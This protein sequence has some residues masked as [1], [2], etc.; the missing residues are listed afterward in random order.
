MKLIFISA[1]KVKNQEILALEKD[2]LRRIRNA[3]V[4]EVPP[5]KQAKGEAAH[6]EAILQV[7]SR[8][9]RLI[10]LDEGGEQLNSK[11]FSALIGKW[12]TQG[13]NSFVFVIGA[14]EGVPPSILQKSDFIWSLSH[15]TFPFQFARLLAIEQVYRGL[16]MLQGHPYHKD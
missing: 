6:G 16:C 11:R 10:A 15:L 14:A 3:Q 2:Y 8:Y 12:C 1:A 5:P 7:A 9:D 13:A 4:L